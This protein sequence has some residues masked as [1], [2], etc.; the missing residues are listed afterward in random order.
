MRI[1]VCVKPVLDPRGITV[2]RKAEKVFVNREEYV[3]DP[4]S[5]AALQVAAALKLNAPASNGAGPVEIAALS[6][7]PDRVDDVLREAMA[8]G[9]D[10][11]MWLKDAA[12]D[13]ADTFVVANALAAAAGHVGAVDVLLLGARSLDTGSGELAGRLAEALDLP[14][15]VGMV[16]LDVIAGTLKGVR[17]SGS[18]FFRAEAQLPAVASVAPEAFEL[19]HANGW[20]LMDAHKRWAVETWSAADLGLSESDLRPMASKKED[21][22]PPERQ[23]GTRVKNVE[24]LVALLK[25]ERVI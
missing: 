24:E 5:K 25:R 19:G 20:R 3:L 9:A 21:A 2:N 23:P 8:F 13:K 11:A 6:L 15:L 7:G 18:A 22:F 12:F 17:R 4:G 16:S 14:L 10:R 1:V